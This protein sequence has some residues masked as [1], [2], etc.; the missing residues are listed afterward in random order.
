MRDGMKEKKCG[1]VIYE[2]GP[3][4]LC[5]AHLTRLARKEERE[6]IKEEKG[7][8]KTVIE[9]CED[10]GHDLARFKEYPS[11]RGKW[12]THCHSCGWIVIVYDEIPHHGGDQINSR[13][14]TEGC[15]GSSALS[16]ALRDSPASDVPVS[17]DD[18]D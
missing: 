10:Y 17:T 15:Q 5:T 12:V 16:S 3:P 14:L 2:Y 1:C 4:V 9:A 13:C 8:R 6:Q 11:Y 18:S 7:L